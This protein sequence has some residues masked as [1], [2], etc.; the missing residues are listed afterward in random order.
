M[1]KRDSAAPSA[2]ESVW[3]WM[4]GR[5]LIWAL[6][7]LAYALWTLWPNS[8]SVMVSWPGVALWWL[9]IALPV[10]GLVGQLWQGRSVLPGL[11]RAA[12]L[13]WG[14]HSYTA[15]LIAI[16]G[17]STLGA[18]LPAQARWHSLALF[19]GL[20]A[21]YGLAGEVRSPQRLRRL[22]QF[23]GGVAIAL[24]GL[25]LALWLSG[26]YWPELA[27]L[28]LIQQDF[29]LSLPF[30]LSILNLRNW[31]PIGHQ[32]Y[33]AGFLVL[34]LPLVAGMAWSSSGW[35][36]VAWGLGG[37]LAIAT[38]YTTGSRGGLVGLAITILLGLGVLGLRSPISTRWRWALLLGGLGAGAALLTLNQR[39]LRL[40]GAIAQGNL[41]EGELVYRWI[42]AVTAW[43]MGR[44]RP[45][46]GQGL[47]SV[48]L[49]YPHYRPAWAGR[50]AELIHQLH[51]TPLQLG[52]ELGI[53]GLL[54]WL[55]AIAGVLALAYRGLRPSAQTG[56]RSWLDAPMVGVGVGLLSYAV[57]SLTDYQLD[58]LC[59]T[60]SLG[61]LGI[62]L[63]IAANSSPAFLPEPGEDAPQRRR[64]RRG[65]LV[66]CGI[67]VATG[68]WWLP[69]GRAW[70]LS[71]SGFTAIA[72][73]QVESFVTRLSA[74]HRLAPWE[75]Y[76]AYQLG[77]NLGELSRQSPDADPDLRSQAIAWF[78]T[79]MIQAP[80]TEFGLS[81]LGWLVGETDPQ[82]ALVPFA[83]AAQR[84]PAKQGVFWA[85]GLHLLRLGEV[86]LAKDAFALEGL[87]HPV[88]LTS[89]VWR[90]PP[91]QDLATPVYD[92]VDAILT[93]GLEASA[94]DDLVSL[95]PHFY[96]VRGSLRWWRGD[97]ATAQSD[98]QDAGL[99]FGP[100]IAAIDQGQIPE[101]QLAAIADPALRLT[102][103]AWQTPEHRREWLAQAWILNTEDWAT[104]PAPIL[105]AL[106]ATQAVST[107]F[108]DWLQNRA[109]SWPRRNERL[110]FGV[111]SRHVDG[112]LPRDYGVLP[113]NIATTYLVDALFPDVVYW[114]ALDRAL[115]PLRDDFLAAV[116][117]LG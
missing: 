62:S 67:L 55:G 117:S 68:L 27:R 12:G 25:S 64:S 33:T 103:Q 6:S 44:D 19:G 5:S 112:P 13:G 23:Q 34:N 4:T 110:A 58:N 88:L 109:P 73:N 14:W 7:A 63:A 98:W 2:A 42:M 114:P 53:G 37:A 83:Q 61:L 24:A 79:A 72:A 100:A 74:A 60:G 90:Q 95:H 99:E 81:S 51:S 65:A 41:G 52:A 94:P 104:P 69:I 116:L 111:I 75:P 3:R 8:N 36:R 35:R 85:I 40:L 102:L 29:G 49:Q 30:N 97:L 59:I 45:L 56:V 113:E 16:V 77:W 54:L 31:Y 15:A 28:R 11:G 82:A 66:L 18:P 71:R 84:V 10:L 106:E 101:A 21:L 20:A 115:E 1:T 43:H 86:N 39:L 47:G 57:F 105:E 93:S 89:P 46:L 80:P 96:Q 22:L 50:E 78:E 107:S 91:L 92:T 32:N 48:P 108:Q 87:R 76:Y 70:A 17:L 38:L 26:V 9:A